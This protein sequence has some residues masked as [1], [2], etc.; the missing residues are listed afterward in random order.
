MLSSN[1]VAKCPPALF[2]SGSLLESDIYA[3]ILVCRDIYASIVVFKGSDDR[4]PK[5]GER[6]HM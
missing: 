3:S 2:A 5:Q 4:R 1:D 6:Q